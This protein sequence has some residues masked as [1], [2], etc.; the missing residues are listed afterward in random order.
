MSLLTRLPIDYLKIDQSFVAELGGQDNK[1]LAFMIINMAKALNL[2]TVAEG[3]ETPLQLERLR[4]A[5]CD[6]MQGY[7]FSKPL[8]VA[9][10]IDFCRN[11]RTGRAG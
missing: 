10:F 4:Q 11:F 6:V 1:K 7:H 2:Q 8:P 3:V 5:E 9:D